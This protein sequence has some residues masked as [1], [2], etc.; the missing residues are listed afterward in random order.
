M[1]LKRLE[2]RQLTPL[3]LVSWEKFF[4]FSFGMMIQSST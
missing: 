2:R 1:A 3:H 4:Y